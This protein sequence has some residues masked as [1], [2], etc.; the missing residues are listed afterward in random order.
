MVGAFDGKRADRLPNS[1]GQDV[2][3]GECL[4]QPDVGGGVRVDPAPVC[5]A[6]PR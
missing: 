5:S 1:P 4:R 3:D 6:A 2:I